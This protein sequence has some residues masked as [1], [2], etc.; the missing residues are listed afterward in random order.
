MNQQRPVVL[1]ADYIVG[2]TFSSTTN[3]LHRKVAAIPRD[4]EYYPGMF[5]DFLQ[6]LM[7]LSTSV[8]LCILA[9]SHLSECTIPRQK[10]SGE[11]AQPPLHWGRG[12]PSQCDRC[13]ILRKTEVKKICYC[14]PF[15]LLFVRKIKHLSDILFCNQS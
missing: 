11:G 12:H 7:F 2:L 15:K 9:T 10:K 8:L 14:K 5:P 6:S 13:F 3:K 1:T 4:A